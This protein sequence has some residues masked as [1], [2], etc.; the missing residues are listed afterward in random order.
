MTKSAE[1]LLKAADWMA[2]QC[3]EGTLTS[4]QAVHE[5]LA[6]VYD[7]LFMDELHDEML[8]SGAA[9]IVDGHLMPKRDGNG[10]T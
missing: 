5:L 2:G 10:H 1:R 7:H 4:K 3:A 6:A 8:A 9:E